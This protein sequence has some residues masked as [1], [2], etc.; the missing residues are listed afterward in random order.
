MGRSSS[1]TVDYGSSSC[2]LHASI[3]IKQ[4]NN[5]APS[6]LFDSWLG[7]SS[8]II[9]DCLE[10]QATGKQVAYLAPSTTC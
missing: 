10:Y 3:T 4:T 2:N 9:V 7:C 1:T 5:G 8:S 6:T